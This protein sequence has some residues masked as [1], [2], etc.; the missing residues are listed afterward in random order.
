[1]SNA[2]RSQ[3][4]VWETIDTAVDKELFEVNVFSLISLARTVT[5]YFLR[6]G[7]GH[8]VITSSTA[9]KLGAPMSASYTASKHAL[10]VCKFS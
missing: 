1:M 2:G 6:T 10:H 5:S 7:S 3:R 8:H 9:G 4:A